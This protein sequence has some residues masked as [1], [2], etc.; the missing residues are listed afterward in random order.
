MNN[1]FLVLAVGLVVAF[2]VMIAYY[3]YIMIAPYIVPLL[4]AF[5]VAMPLAF[6]RDAFI[7]A[8]E[9]AEISLGLSK[10][11]L[12]S[13][14]AAAFVPLISVGVG[15]V[16]STYSDT[17]SLRESRAAFFVRFSVYPLAHPALAIL[18][19]IH[20][21]A[22]WCAG[23]PPPRALLLQ[24]GARVEEQS[25]VS[26]YYCRHCLLACHCSVPSVLPDQELLRGVRCGH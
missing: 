24:R 26:H 18:S 21:P 11:P 16:T 20:P 7:G 12:V 3:N 8:I 13:L 2:F 15:V 9:S 1:A 4:M 17:Q 5:L 22:L 6:I 10:R 14:L 23:V 25:R 19:S